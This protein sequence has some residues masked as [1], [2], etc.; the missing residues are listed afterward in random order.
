MN[1]EKDT[2]CKAERLSS[3]KSIEMLF[4]GTAKS[5]SAF[6]LRVI[7]MPVE[8]DDK[9]PASVLISVPKKRFKRAV[10]RNRVKRQVREAYRKNKHE[11]LG[12]LEEQQIK[13]LV[14]FIFMHSELHSSEEIEKKVKDLLSRIV[15]R[16]EKKE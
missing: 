5:F 14:A 10:K 13:L 1:K 3:K 11:L 15:G 16:L 12:L 9:V 2:L 7:F 8:P 4:A 6:P